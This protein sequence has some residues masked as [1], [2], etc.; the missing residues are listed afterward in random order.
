M[1]INQAG[2]VFEGPLLELKVDAFE[3]FFNEPRYRFLRNDA[4]GEA[5]RVDFLD[6][7]RAVIRNATYTTCQRAAGPEL[8][9]RLDP[10]R[11]HAS[12]STR[13]KRSARPSGARAELHGRARSCRCRR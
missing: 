3:G 1:R 10:A 13:R 2:N 8:D 5:D 9:A 11:R 4:Y 12:A 7:N 6:E